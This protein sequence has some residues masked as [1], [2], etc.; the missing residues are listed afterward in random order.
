MK[1]N[2]RVFPLIALG[3]ALGTMGALAQQNQ[4]KLAEPSGGAQSFGMDMKKH[5]IAD[6]KDA[7]ADGRG[8]DSDEGRH[9][10]NG[11]RRCGHEDPHGNG[12]SQ[13]EEPD[14]PTAG[15]N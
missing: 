2:L 12:A 10:E 15:G 6:G 11:G 14:G 3:V 13:H 7:W 9:G 4:S 1:L 5:E 8:A